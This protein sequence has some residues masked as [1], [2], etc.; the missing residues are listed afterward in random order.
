MILSGIAI[1]AAFAVITCSVI[2]VVMGSNIWPIAAVA[3]SVST[4]PFAMG[5]GAFA[6]WV[7][8]R[9]PRSIALAGLVLSGLALATVIGTIMF[10]NR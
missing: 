8:R 5:T 2:P 4:V 1:H 3:W 10:N 9:L 7:A 6:G